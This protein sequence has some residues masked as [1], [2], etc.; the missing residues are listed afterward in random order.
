LTIPFDVLSVAAGLFGDDDLAKGI[1]DYGAILVKIVT[2]SKDFADAA[3]AIAK[4]IEQLD[5]ITFDQVLLG[6]SIGFNVAMVAVAIGLSGLLSQSKPP[7]QVILEQ[8]NEIRKQIVD[9]RNEMRVRFDRLESRL[10]ATCTPGCSTS[11]PRWTSTSARSR[12]TSTSSR[13]PLYDL[14]ADPSTASS[15]SAS[16]PARTLPL[17]DF[18]DGENQFF[19]WGHDHALDEVAPVGRLEERVD[20]SGQPRKGCAAVRPRGPGFHRSAVPDW[21]VPV[22]EAVRERVAPAGIR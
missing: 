7:T 20:V 16:G 15:A 5:H 9:L 18:R 3:I 17:E 1:D 6:A 19:S 11:W 2:S 10:N 12:A 4:V 8:L 21:R 22:F 14:H 13:S